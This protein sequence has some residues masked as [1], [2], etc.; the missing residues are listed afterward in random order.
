[1]A[2]IVNLNIKTHKH[3]IFV[4]IVLTMNN[5]VSATNLVRITFLNHWSYR[6]LKKGARLRRL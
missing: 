4:S 3:I 2:S 6:E 1:M 5:N